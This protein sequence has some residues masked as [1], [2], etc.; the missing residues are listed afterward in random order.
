MA[1]ADP[2]LKDRLLNDLSSSIDSGQREPL[3]LSAAPPPVISDHT[4]LRRIGKGSYGEVWLARN[5]M[6]TFRAVKVVHRG[7]FDSDRPYEREFAGIRRFEPVSRTHPSQLSVLHVGRDD[8]AGH[9]YYVME[10]ADSVTPVFQPAD[11]ETPKD[12]TK[13]DAP[14]RMSALQKGSPAGKSALQPETY[15][16]RTLRSEL[17]H[18]GSLPYGECMAIGTALATALDHLHRHG[19]VHRDIKPSNIIFVNG[20]PKLADIGLVTHVEATLSFVGTEGFVPP[21]GPGTTQADI[22]SL[23]KVLYEMSTGRDRQEYPELPTNLLERPAAERASLEE[24]NEIVL[25][26]C[27]PDPKQRY[28][29]AAE[30]HADLAL[31][32]SGRSVVRLRGI[33]RRLRFVQRA[34]A[35]VTAIAALVAAGWW[36]QARQTRVVRELAT[37][38]ASLLALE[39]S[40]RNKADQAE[41]EAVGERN[42]ARQSEENTDRVLDFL[43]QRVV[44]AARPPDEDGDGMGRGVTVL[45]ALRAVEPRIQETFVGQPLAELKLRQSLAATFHL[46]GLATNHIAN[47]QRALELSETLF[48]AT[49]LETFSNRL[50]LASAYSDLGLMT[51]AVAQVEKAWRTAS[52]AFGET[53]ECALMALAYLGEVYRDSGR[54]ADAIGLLEAGV[55]MSTQAFGAMHLRTLELFNALAWSYHRDGQSSRAVPLLEQTVA[56]RER[57]L[58]RDHVETTRAML[59]LGRVYLAVGQEKKGF[60]VLREAYELRRRAQGPQH[61]A[62]LVA[63]DSLARS[64]ER[65]GRTNDALAWHTLALE[66]REAKLGPEHALGPGQS[67]TVRSRND[68][69]RLRA[70]LGGTTN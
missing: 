39:E 41:K 23:G 67:S 64:F 44:A 30:M 35:V 33:E 40:A 56:G 15:S 53:N 19:L 11:A 31:L 63:V 36:W 21:E 5:V 69:L 52:S 13:A 60:A 45:E 29:T 59:D 43:L 42:R 7:A 22:Y 61:Q 2:N 9:F 6:G 12:G 25:R 16:P 3:D 50:D 1:K 26:A 34:G 37:E 14:T 62:T 68:V 58:G 47:R 4:L 32:E 27:N 20:I 18:R 49:S 54:K 66:L 38:N 17:H 48:G 51:D 70:V 28:V 46:L 8:A 24:L 65:V 57:A 55:R 10:L